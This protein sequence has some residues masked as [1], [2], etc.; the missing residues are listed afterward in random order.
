MY[1]CV[2]IVLDFTERRYIS[3]T[4]PV[5]ITEDGEG[6]TDLA[7]RVSLE[8]VA[9]NPFDV[10]SSFSG[11]VMAELKEKLA[12]LTLDT[13]QFKTGGGLLLSLCPMPGISCTLLSG[14]L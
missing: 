2:S 11:E 7:F 10:D 5:Y 9:A 12:E 13:S 4:S 6:V 3:D 8:Q 1:M 14:A